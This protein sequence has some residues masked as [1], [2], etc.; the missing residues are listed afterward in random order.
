MYL[1]NEN[2]SLLNTK[3]C[4]ENCQL[5]THYNNLHMAVHYTVPTVSIP[6]NHLR[7]LFPTVGRNLG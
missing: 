1:M 3:N 2:V 5:L 6:P 4:D 7:F